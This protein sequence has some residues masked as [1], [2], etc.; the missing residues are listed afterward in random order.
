M[1]LVMEFRDHSNVVYL[2]E[3]V[4]SLD[5]GLALI[6]ANH[7]LVPWHTHSLYNLETGE[8]WEFKACED[9]IKRWELKADEDHL[10]V[11]NADL[12]VDPDN[13]PGAEEVQS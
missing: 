7:M 9:P 2:S 13:L 3:E 8:V 6:E 11:D 1:K 4:N 10:I 12:D 5:E